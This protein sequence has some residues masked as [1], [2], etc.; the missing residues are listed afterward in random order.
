M[1]PLLEQFKSN[2]ISKGSSKLTVKNYIVDIKKFVNWYEAKYQKTFGP[3]DITQ[4][5]LDE[6]KKDKTASVSARSVERYLSSLRKFFTFLKEQN[7]IPQS[8]FEIGNLKFE[9]G[10]SDPWKIKEFKDYLYVFGSSDLTIKNYILDIQ[11]FKIWCEETLVAKDEYLISHSHPLKK[12]SPEIIEEYKDRL[13]NIMRFA[14]ASINRKLSSIR[15]YCEFAVKQNYIHLAEAQSANLKAPVCNALRSIAGRQSQNLKLKA[16]ESIKLEDLPTNSPQA[17]G[18]GPRAYSS[19]PP[20]RLAQKVLRPFTSLEEKLEEKIANTISKRFTQ[21]NKQIHTDPIRENPLSNPRI[22]NIPKGFY[23]PH[24]IS[25]KNYPWHKKI[26]HHTRHTRPQWYKTYHNYAFSHYLHIAILVIYASAVGFAIYQTL[27][28]NPN[29]KPTLAATAPPRILSFQARLTDAADTPITTATDLRFGIYNDDAASG[30]ALLWQ[31]V[32]YSITPDADGIFSV[33][34]GTNT[35]IEQ[36]VF[37]NNDTLYLGVSI[38]QTAEL[39]PRQRLAAV[40]YATNAELLQGMMP[41]TAVGAGQTNVILALDSSGNLSIGGAANPTFEATGGQFK[42]QGQ[43]LLLTT[44]TGSDGNVTIVPD[45]LGRID[46]QKALTNTTSNGT[47]PGAVEI[48]DTLQITATDSANAALIVNNNGEGDL[49][50]ASASGVTKFRIDTSGNASVAGT[51]TV[52]QDETIRPEYGNLNFAYKS[53]PDAWTTGMVID[54]NGNI[55]IGTTNPAYKLD[56]Q[57]TGSFSDTLTLGSTIALPNGNTLTG[58]ADYVNFSQGIGTNGTSRLTTA[59]ALENVTG[60]TQTS[61]T[62]DINSNILYVNDTN[63]GIGTDSPNAKLDIRGTATISSTLSLGPMLEVDAGICSVSSAGKMYYDAAQNNYLYCNGSSWGA[64]A[65]SLWQRNSGTLAPYNITDDLLIGGLSTSAAK[66]GFINMAAGTPTATF[67]SNLSLQVPTG[68][69]PNTLLN[70]LN[71]GTLNVQTSGGGDA[72]L[73]S[74]LYLANNGNIG[75][76]TTTPDS[77]FDILAESGATQLRLSSTD[78]STYTDIKTDQ[79]G[80]LYIAPSGGS[81]TIAANLQV[82]GAATISGNTNISGNLNTSGYTTI[83]ASLNVGYSTAPVGVGNAIFSGQVGIGVTDPASALQIAGDILPDA[84]GTRM[85][86][87]DSLYWGSIYVN[88]IIS[89]SA[90]GIAAYWQLLNGALSPS[91]ITNSLNL[92]S[93]AT[94][95]AITH[96]AA[97]ASDN[98]FYNGTGNF[99][100]GTSTPTEKLDVAGDIQLYNSSTERGEINTTNSITQDKTWTTTT[101]FNASGATSSPQVSAVSNEI[102]LSVETYGTGA[103]GDVTFTSADTDLTLTNKTSGRTCADG[104]DAVNY[105][106]LGLPAANQATLSATPSDGCLAVGDEIL[107]INLQGT[108]GNSANVGNYETLFIQSV[109]DNTVTFESNKTNNYG[110]G[111]EDDTFIGTA[112][113]TQRVMLQRIPQ[114]DDITIDS[115]ATVKTS[116]WNGTKGGVLFFRAT[117]TLTNNGV[118]TASSSGYRAGNTYSGSTGGYQGEGYKGTGTNQNAAARKSANTEGGGTAWDSSYNSGLA[119]GGG[120]GGYGVAG[121]NGT[122]SHSSYAGQGSGGTTYGSDNLSTLFLGSAGGGGGSGYN[123]SWNQGNST[124]DGKGGDGGGIIYIGAKTLTNSGY[125]TATGS[126]GYN[127]WGHNGSTCGQSICGGA[128]GGGAGGSIYVAGNDLTLG[129]GTIVATGGAK[130]KG[131][132]GSYGGGW[133]PSESG[134]G[135]FGRITIEYATSLSGNST[136]SAYTVEDATIANYASG[137]QYWVSETQDAG[138]GLTYKPSKFK[139]SWTLDGSDNIVPKFQVLASST[140]DFTG[141]QT[142]YPAGEGAYYQDGG[143]YDI[144]SGTEIDISSQVTTSFRYWKVKAY[145]DT[146]ATKTDTPSVQDIRLRDV[147]KPLILQAQSGRNVAIGTTSATAKLDVAGDASISGS[148]VFR[149]DNPTIDI[150]NNGRLDI[151]GSPGG[152]DLLRLI[153]SILSNGYVGVGTA[154]PFAKLH[155]S[156]G[157]IYVDPGYGL[158]ASTSGTLGIGTE[159]ARTTEIGRTADGTDYVTDIYGMQ[160]TG[161]SISDTISGRDNVVLLAMDNSFYNSRGDNSSIKIG[162]RADGMFGQ[163][164][165]IGGYTDTSRGTYLTFTRGSQVTG[166]NYDTIDANQ[167]SVSLWIKPHWASTDG[168]DKV[169]FEFPSLMRLIYNASTDRFNFGYWNG[170]EYTTQIVPSLEQTFSTDAWQ[171]IA[172]SW[173][174]DNAPYLQIKVNADVT[175]KY[176][177]GAI[178]PQT[179]SATNYIGSDSNGT[180]LAN[181]LLDDFIVTNNVLRSTESGTIS[182]TANSTAVTGT[183]SYFWYLYPYDMIKFTGDNTFY[184]INGLTNATSLVLASPAAITLADVTYQAGQVTALYNGGG[185]QT[186]SSIV[187][188]GDIKFYAKMDGSGSYSTSL[189]GLGYG[190]NWRAYDVSTNTNGQKLTNGTM[191]ADTA[192]VPDSWTEVGSPT[193]ADAESYNTYMDLRSQK[194]TV[195][196]ISKGIYHTDNIAVTAGDNYRVQAYIKSDGTNRANIRVQNVTAGNTITTIG[197]INKDW[198]LVTTDF[199]IPVGAEN[200]TVYIESGTAASYSFYVDNVGLWKLP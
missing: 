80:N 53:G 88:N 45:G 67:S 179:P 149:D 89:P 103:D 174:A 131:G 134:P 137:E 184:N 70:I 11:D 133:N 87:S 182:T 24:S 13:L 66:I 188:S 189:S 90:G 49:F 55:G 111:A 109:S 78:N 115:G 166:N 192:G 93:T 82:N 114:Y 146:G 163:A 169:I 122:Y 144:N 16:A 27:F 155:V 15:K 129:T 138:A 200:I 136:P 185:G 143:T 106:V 85:I 119:E 21:I 26:I 94:T 153:L 124:T 23:T 165:G 46:L 36:S 12:I 84:S 176:L 37:A 71:G 83:G 157:N 76:G 91:F 99:G 64:V 9:I 197:T 140:G 30:G 117:G 97:T 151:Q 38:D 148:L 5:V 113:S 135:G 101:D 32:Q 63:V 8:P 142:I 68:I 132:G 123:G 41:I 61:G 33:L 104:G 20:L 40:A 18:H 95:S 34:L 7:I 199:Q 10:N 96:L 1:N 175:Q 72:G 74:R 31:E 118:I 51:I 100:I 25:I 181:A 198:T 139:A 28:A 42:L 170:S 167:G 48:R 190:I 145:L 14:P 168:V 152:D 81:A 120:G 158:D 187:N 121:G 180:N 60:Y 50:T 162:Y 44:T 110:H 171:Y 6:F 77:K 98:S 73:A 58:D 59:G 3:Q 116:A 108:A 19:I 156:G 17:T 79:T 147:D 43:T 102:K 186:A 57:G 4:F 150:L 141:E 160:A 161:Y 196:G 22:S 183:N 35:A 75:I 130:T 107:I 191:E 29:I 178:T 164:I 39:T 195:T 52:G 54:Q 128:G 86:G 127:G 62:L 193:S 69:D 125:I 92:G 173:D 126:A 65:S 2:L 194:I 47:H 159:N 154:N 112:T 172:V 105:S 177:E 56:T